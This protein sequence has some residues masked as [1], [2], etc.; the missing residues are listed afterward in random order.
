MC[1]FLRMK[2]GINITQSLLDYCTK[3]SKDEMLRQWHPNRNGDL[4]PEKTTPFSN[5]KVWWICE[6]GHPFQATVASRTRLGNGCPYC[7]GHKALAGFNDLAT[8]H[9]DVA[10]QWHPHLN[11]DLTPQAVT[12]GSHKKVWWQCAD[13]HVWQARVDTRTDHRKCGCPVCAGKIST[14]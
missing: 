8:R 14:K 3:L 13:G 9:P 10:A 11:G 1:I 6:K 2:G 7:A 4:T 12:P 5:R